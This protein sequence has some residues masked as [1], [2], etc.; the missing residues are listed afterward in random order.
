MVR[1]DNGQDGQK[2]KYTQPTRRRR[3]KKL[4]VIWYIHIWI[5]ILIYPD[6][7]TPGQFSFIQ[8]S[9]DFICDKN[10]WT[11]CVNFFGTFFYQDLAFPNN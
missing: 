7:T 4:I 3:P 9:K 11:F 5:Y 6:T 1:T 8:D 2:L 10:C